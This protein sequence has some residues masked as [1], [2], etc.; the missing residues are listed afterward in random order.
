MHSWISIMYIMEI[1]IWLKMNSGLNSRTASHTISAHGPGSDALTMAWSLI[2][3]IKYVDKSTLRDNALLLTQDYFFEKKYYVD[4][5]RHL[6][7]LMPIYVDL[8]RQINKKATR[9]S[10]SSVEIRVASQCRKKIRVSN[11]NSVWLWEIRVLAC[12]AHRKFV[13]FLR[14]MFTEA[15]R[16]WLGMV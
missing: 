5:N 1:R 11:E 4:I 15:L 13:T 14:V 6:C 3:V 9:R 7:R 10:Q 16:S 12:Y 8:F 2:M